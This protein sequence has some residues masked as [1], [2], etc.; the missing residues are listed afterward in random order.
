MLSTLV[1]THLS[2]FAY[3]EKWVR[4][5]DE[6]EGGLEAF[7]RGYERFGFNEQLDGGI[8]YAEW[9]PGAVAASLI[10]DFSEFHQ[11]YASLKDILVVQ[12][13]STAS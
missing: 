12:P 13:T 9:A 2:R 11:L 5:I 3:F 7:S 6:H 4:D 8:R 1:A 10:G